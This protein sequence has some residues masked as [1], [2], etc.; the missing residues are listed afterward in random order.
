[1]SDKRSPI[2][3]FEIDPSEITLGQL[4]SIEGK[5][6]SLIRAVTGDLV[7]VSPKAVGWIVDSV[8]SGSPIVY[9]LRPQETPEIPISE[10]APAVQ[11][12][13][14][15]IRAL[16]EGAVRP[17]HF[18]DTAMEK[19]RDLATVLGDRVRALRFYSDGA[20]PADFTPKVAANVT[21][22]LHEDQYE[23]LGTV[24]GRLE[25]VSVH[26]K[27]YF[28]VY[29]DLDG[30]KVQ[31]LFAASE[32]P[33]DEI[34]AAIGS[35]VAVFGILTSRESGRV[36]RVKVQNLEVFPDPEH[37]PSFEDVAGIVS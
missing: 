2:L 21:I 17:P 33:A 23:S 9:A 13:V 12:I 30:T 28:N 6:S 7:G 10:L 1:M 25:A 22:A 26:D 37:L 16:N 3:R 8:N 4:I 20:P 14:D 24:E 34:G 11:V 31:C 29:R 36:V 5:V 27:K 18:N 15:G 32:I 19:A 35:R